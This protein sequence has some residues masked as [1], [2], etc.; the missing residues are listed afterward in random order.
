M[1]SIHGLFIQNPEFMKILIDAGYDGLT[2]YDFG[3]R[4][5]FEEQPV[6]MVVNAARQV[7][8]IDMVEVTQADLHYRHEPAN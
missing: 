7:T 1:A 4:S 6:W 3:F 2:A 5:D 8:M